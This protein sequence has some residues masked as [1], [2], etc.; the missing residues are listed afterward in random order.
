[1]LAIF[2]QYELLSLA[3]EVYST[4]NEKVFQDLNDYYV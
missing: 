3:A 4:I 1:M 2:R